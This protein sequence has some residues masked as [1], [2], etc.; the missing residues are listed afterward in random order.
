MLWRTA[1]NDL[2]WTRNGLAW[3]SGPPTLC[4]VLAFPTHHA[5]HVKARIAAIEEVV[6]VNS[7]CV[8]KVSGSMPM[9]PDADAAVGTV[10]C[11]QAEVEGMIG[12]RPRPLEAGVAVGADCKFYDSGDAVGCSSVGCEEVLGGLP[13]PLEVAL[14]D[15]V[16]CEHALGSSVDDDN[17]AGPAAKLQWLGKRFAELGEY[18]RMVEDPQADR[19]ELR[20]LVKERRILQRMLGNALGSGG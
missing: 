11:D 16:D 17:L 19:T 3:R 2:A 12:R 18:D 5:G 14:A 13:R 15:K 9:L 6:G 20:Q 10:G 1:Q 4:V 8:D 7:A